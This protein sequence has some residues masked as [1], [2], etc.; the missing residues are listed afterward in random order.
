MLTFIEYLTE[1]R[2]QSPFREK[3]KELYGYLKAIK[4]A[5]PISY[6]DKVKF[7]TVG[8]QRA[9][10]GIKQYIKLDKSKTSVEIDAPIDTE[11]TKTAK[12]VATLLGIKGN[13]KPKVTTKHG[14]HFYTAFIRTIEYKGTI[15]DSYKIEYTATMTSDENK[16]EHN[17]SH[18]V[19]LIGKKSTVKTSGF[20]DFPNI[21]PGTIFSASWGYDMT[22]VEY[23][24]VVKRTGKSVYV[25]PIASKTDGDGHAG[26]ATPVKD[27]F[28]SSTATRCVLKGNPQD[29]T[30]KSVYININGHH[31]KVWDGKPNYYNTMD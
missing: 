11:F 28:T 15:E 17:I 9:E 8:E 2:G 12:T 30:N 13:V 5:K 25:R 20:T 18:E 29:T 21:V 7:T 1:A 22:I 19:V 14:K 24:Q 10:F 16:L 26:N 27:S 6:E 3:A 31:G 4:G 23:W